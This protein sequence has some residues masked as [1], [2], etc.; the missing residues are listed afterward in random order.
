[1]CLVMSDSTL[2]YSSYVV[3]SCTSH[4]W[5]LPIV[6]HEENVIVNLTYIDHQEKER[7]GS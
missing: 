5:A 4:S 2:G 1:M 3:E 7:E 6:E